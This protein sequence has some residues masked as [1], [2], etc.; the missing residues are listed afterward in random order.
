M[1]AKFEEC[2][3]PR[4]RREDCSETAEPSSSTREARSGSPC[5]ART[6]ELAASTG[7]G[8][9][10]RVTV[11]RRGPSF[12]C[13]STF[14]CPDTAAGRPLLAPPGSSPT[15]RPRCITSSGRRRASVLQFRARRQHRGPAFRRSPSAP[16]PRP[17]PDVEAARRLVEEEQPRRRYQPA[18]STTFCW[19]PPDSVCTGCATF[20][21]LIFRRATCLRR[22]SAAAAVDQA[23]PVGH[24]VEVRKA[25]W[26]R[27]TAEQQALA[28]AVLGDE[29]QSA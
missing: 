2:A 20:A 15:I 16:D 28:P 14:G 19:L 27:P 3:V 6:P 4:L 10:R 5:R 12:S 26:R 29:A 1:L 18:A 11:E 24:L 7:A 17:S 21:S 25:T 22:S 9:D 23:E 8:H 13:A